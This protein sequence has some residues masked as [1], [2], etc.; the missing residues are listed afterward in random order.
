[1]VIEARL[2]M[3]THLQNSIAN[4][5]ACSSGRLLE[6]LAPLQSQQQL[7][8]QSSLRSR[9][10]LLQGTGLHSCKIS[11]QD[12]RCQLSGAHELSPEKALVQVGVQ[13]LSAEPQPVRPVQD[14]ARSRGWVRPGAC[15]L[16]RQVSDQE[17]AG[18]R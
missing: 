9:Q 10:L 1:M 15:C 8:P 12:A 17:R 4:E 16:A 5:A 11:S 14:L 2:G 6:P 3:P 18:S 7:L 13:A